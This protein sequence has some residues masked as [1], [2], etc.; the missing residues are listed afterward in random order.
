MQHTLIPQK[1]RR[2]LRREYRIRAFIVFCFLLSVG[3]LIGSATLFPSFIFT[4]NEEKDQL[5][6]LS[7]IRET[8]DESGVTALELD[9]KRDN[10]L[11][12]VLSKESKVPRPSTS[13]QS[14]IGLRGPVKI[15]AISVDTPTPE[16]LVIIIQGIAPN[17]D[18]LLAFKSRLEELAGGGVELPVSDL[19]KSKDLQFSM[20]IIENFK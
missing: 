15:N 10:S 19:A 14:V 3:G 7:S 17:R 8:K 9:F 12:S 13:I 4:F 16:D 1:E 2:I 18:S 20:R 5:S 11:I 6:L